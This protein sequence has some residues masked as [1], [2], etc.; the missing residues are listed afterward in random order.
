MGTNPSNFKGPQNPVEQV[1]W[2]DIQEYT[3]RLNKAQ[4]KYT[5][6][7]PT[8]AEWEYAA[9]A[10]SKG[11]YYFD[12]KE[13]DDHAWYYKNSNN[14]THP[15]EQKKPNAWGLYDTV[16]NVWEWVE[17]WYGKYPDSPITGSFA[18]IPGG[19]RARESAARL[20]H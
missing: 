8:E 14:V 20:A 13:I 17:D 10:G 5:H 18:V 11:P 9:R 3:K 19:A 16:G 15:V 6:R 1:S 4:D 2:D 7:L 12:E